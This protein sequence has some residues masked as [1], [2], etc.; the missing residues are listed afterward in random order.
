MWGRWDLA[1][2]SSVSSLEN[3]ESAY[4]MLEGIRVDLTVGFVDAG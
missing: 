3:R 4:E 2:L 1:S